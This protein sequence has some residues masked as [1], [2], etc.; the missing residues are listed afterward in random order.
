MVGSGKYKKY[1]GHAALWD[2]G[3]PIQD[4]TPGPLGS[5]QARPQ[6]VKRAI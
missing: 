6:R 3:Y 4:E 5:R 1:H 2:R